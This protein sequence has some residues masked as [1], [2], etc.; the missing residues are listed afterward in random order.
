MVDYEM[1]PVT[2]AS[3]A[4]LIPN[5]IQRLRAAM[6]SDLVPSAI[7]G[8]RIRGAGVQLFTPRGPPHTQK[9]IDCREHGGCFK[10]GNRHFC[11]NCGQI[12]IGVSC[13]VGVRR[14]QAPLV[15][16]TICLI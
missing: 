13:G 8:V 7:D 11:D 15:K 5:A 6:V 12:E 3:E 10:N 14:P 1:E 16:Q 9:R 4:P 2:E